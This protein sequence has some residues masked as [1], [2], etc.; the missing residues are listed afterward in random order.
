MS[1]PIESLIDSGELILFSIDHF[2]RRKAAGTK[3]GYVVRRFVSRP[4]ELSDPGSLI[5][6]RAV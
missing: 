2:Y 4:A 1:P 5:V 3:N 6:V